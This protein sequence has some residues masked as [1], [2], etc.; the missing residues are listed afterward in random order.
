MMAYKYI[1]HSLSFN[2]YP[3][4]IHSKAYIHV[5]HITPLLIGQEKSSFPYSTRKKGPPKQPPKKVH[6]HLSYLPS[7]LRMNRPLPFLLDSS[8]FKSLYFLSTVVSKT[9]AFEIK[10]PVQNK[11]LYT[12]TPSTKIDVLHCDHS[13]FK[14]K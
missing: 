4:K 12:I 14:Y 1:L 2:I 8:S 3:Y 11:M 10:T 5:R 7:T 6:P 9:F 13:I